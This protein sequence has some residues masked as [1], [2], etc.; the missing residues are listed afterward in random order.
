MFEAF[1]IT[2]REGIEA[3]LVI[4]II[5][6]FL[7]RSGRAHLQRWV[8]WG[9]GAA[10]AA[11]LGAAAALGRLPIN[12][13]AYEGSLMLLAA[14]FVVSMV[15]W[16]WH[17]GRT[18]KREI[19]G[20]LS[21]V[22]ARDGASI[23]W[24]LFAVTFLMIFR[25]GAE[26]VL[27]LATTRLTTEDL[28]STLGALGGL[29]L[30]TLFGIALVQ[31]SVRI[32]IGRF[33]QVTSV[34][35]LVFAAHLLISSVHEYAEAGVIPIGPRT[36]RTLGPIV[37]SQALVMASLL[38]I[39]VLIYLF[40]SRRGATAPLPPPGPERRLIQARARRDRRWRRVAGFTGL[41][42]VLSLT[43]SIAYSRFPQTFDAPRMVAADAGG[44]VR[45]PLAGLDDGKLHRF[46]VAIDG[47]VVRF[48]IL[49]TGDRLQAAFDACQVCGAYGYVQASGRLICLACAAD[50]NPRTV[51]AE[52][53]CNPIPLELEVAGDE[54][55]VRLEDLRSQ[56]PA[57]AAAATAAAAVPG[58]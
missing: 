2:L 48:L 4:G 30:A 46:G 32:D 11:S 16:M 12:E 13:E 18:M 21:K 26:T 25:E 6:V 22:A 24:G 3:A 9:L 35:L 1:I 56:R 23:G 37:K 29:G 5:L 55:I 44:N 41:A 28:L 19:E 57:F 51:G 27:L 8:F 50:I 17:A 53:G 39:P 45:V 14:V 47:V 54:A 36:M 58:R 34:V 49:Q 31:G 7:R 20:R 33:F 10:M 15:A 38:A 52:G 43:V 40:P 42:V